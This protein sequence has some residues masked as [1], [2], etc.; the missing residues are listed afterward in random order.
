LHTI[1]IR[2]DR[3]RQLVWLYPV[4]KHHLEHYLATGIHFGL[5]PS[6]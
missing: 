3:H 2:I 6:R 4:S 1:R 5:M